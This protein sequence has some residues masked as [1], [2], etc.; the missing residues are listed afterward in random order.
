MRGPTLAERAPLDAIG[1][2]RVVPSG[3][4]CVGSG[5]GACKHVAAVETDCGWVCPE[6]W[7]LDPGP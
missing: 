6:P 7:T 3:R 1:A 4:A 2:L 5:S